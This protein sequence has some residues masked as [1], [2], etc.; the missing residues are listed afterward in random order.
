LIFKALLDKATSFRIEIITKK[1]FLLI[2]EFDEKICDHP[3]SFTPLVSTHALSEQEVHALWYD[4]AQSIVSDQRF[5]D[6]VSDINP[7]D[8]D[9][10]VR[11][12]RELLLDVIDESQ[13]SEPEYVPYI[14]GLQRWN[15]LKQSFLQFCRNIGM[16]EVDFFDPHLGSPCASADIFYDAD[17]FPLYVQFTDKNKSSLSET[18]CL[19]DDIAFEFS[20]LNRV[21][22]LTMSFGINDISSHSI[23]R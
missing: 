9:R 23:Q 8:P 4:L 1:Y 2:F 10:Y 20:N 12:A 22:I 5:L 13:K 14:S 19:S 18:I 6:R 16:G 7:N 3:V 11:A 15:N 21:S 17:D